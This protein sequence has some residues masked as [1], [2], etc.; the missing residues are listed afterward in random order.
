MEA[1]KNEPIINILE[2]EEREESIDKNQKSV[3]SATNQY[4]N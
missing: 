4:S 1:F 2:M 3:P